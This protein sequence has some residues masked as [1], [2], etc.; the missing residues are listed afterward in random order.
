MG[1]SKE[2]KG[3]QPWLK[4]YTGDWLKKTR[5]LTLAAKGAYMDLR[6]FMW[7]NEPRGEL[8]ETWEGFARLLGCS[9]KD[10]ETL[11]NLLQQKSC[12]SLEIAAQP[13]HIK[14]IDPEMNHDIYISE[15]RSKVAKDAKTGDSGKFAAA[16][17]TTKGKNFAEAKAKQNPDYDYDYDNGNGILTEKSLSKIFDEGYLD[18]LRMAFSALDIDQELADFK[19]KVR[20]APEDYSNRDSAGLRSAFL[21]QLRENRTK[22]PNTKPKRNGSNTKDEHTSTL[23]ADFAKRHGAAPES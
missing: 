15:I 14:A 8:T 2:E 16:N 3:K 9:E 22:K 20:G 4:T 21:Y 23:V 17:T 12:I 10:A 6:V 18:P 1:K 19:L 7:D 11:L 5:V 13:G